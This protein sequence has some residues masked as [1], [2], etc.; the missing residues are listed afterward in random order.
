MES[1]NVYFRKFEDGDVIA[2]WDD[3]DHGPWITSYMHI[4][5]HSE[6]SRELIT[7][8]AIATHGEYGP[9]KHELESIGYS[10]TLAE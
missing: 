3:G 7:D 10:V 5:Q 9:L 2:L 4:G 1:I 6:A 8:L